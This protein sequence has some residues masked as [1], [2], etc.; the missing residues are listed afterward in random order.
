MEEF[1]KTK[2]GQALKKLGIWGAFLLIV[3][4]VVTVFD[5]NTVADN[6]KKEEII[7]EVEVNNNDLLKELLNSNYEY[8]YNITVGDKEYTFVGEYSQGIDKGYK[9]S[10]EEIIK[11]EIENGIVY[12]IVKKQR[13]EID[14]FYNELNKDY[15]DLSFINILLEHEPSEVYTIDGIQFN[16]SSDGKHITKIEINSDN[17][18]Y[19]LEFFNIEVY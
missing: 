13:I 16:V 14:N 10:D 2:R 1:W 11:Y 3:L 17:Y 9:E 6:D 19:N 4:F 18:S 8:E 5:D 15:L 7:D 12:Q